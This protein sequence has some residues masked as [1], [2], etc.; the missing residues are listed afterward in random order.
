MSEGGAIAMTHF[1]GLDVSMVDTAV[2]I[3]DDTGKL[4]REQKVPTEPNDIVTLLISVGEDYGRVGIEAVFWRGKPFG[5]R[6][7][8]L[9]DT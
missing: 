4:V 7:R 6:L 5:R 3:I 1:V 2:C 8:L 9:P